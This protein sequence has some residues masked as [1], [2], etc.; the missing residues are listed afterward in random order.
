MP[1]PGSRSASS[2]TRRCS[3]RP[4][5]AR[6]RPPALVDRVVA[7]VLEP[8]ACRCGTSRPSRSPRRPPPSCGTGCGPRSSAARPQRRPA[9]E[10][11]ARGAGARRPRRRRDRHAALLRPAH[12]H[13]APDRGRPAAAGRGPRRG[14]RP[15]SRSTTAGRRCATELLD[16]PAPRRA[17][18]LALAA[19][20]TPR[21][22]CA[23]WRPR[24]TAN[25]D[26]LADRSSP[27][28]PARCPRSTPAAI[29]A[30]ARRLAAHDRATAP[31]AP[32]SSCARLTGLSAWAAM[33]AERRRRRRPASPSLGRRRRAQVVAT[34]SSGTGRCDLADVK[35]RLRRAGGTRPPRSAA[36]CCDVA[37]RRLAYRIA[38][39]DASHDAQ[40]RRAR[41]PARVPRPAGARP[42]AAAQPRPRVGRAG[43]AAASATSGCCSTSSRTPTRSRSSS[44]C[45]SPAALPPA[46]RRL[47]RRR[48][49]AR[50]G[51]SS[52]A[53]RSSR[54]TGSAGPTSP[55]S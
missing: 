50:V 21:R 9:C 12:P 36:G 27:R 3:S 41:G 51:C 52:S 40:E 18:L 43:R 24:S 47:G 55:P 15:G 35:E 37:L 29:V 45:A 25:W 22:T 31:T 1:P 2:S 39:A 46:T 30:D 20:V 26:L 11:T 16:D 5:P 32:T 28:H 17:L 13:R 23:R 48:R 54:S 38:E 49:A 4:A 42:R 14:R 19:G 6:A 44:P 53:T 33:L 8:C 10:A 34:G 7:L